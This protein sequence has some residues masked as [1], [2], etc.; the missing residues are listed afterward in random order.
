MP[1]TDNIPEEIWHHIKLASLPFHVRAVFAYLPQRLSLEAVLPAEREVIPLVARQLIKLALGSTH[2]D[3]AE[4]RL[5][6][7]ASQ[8]RVSLSRGTRACVLDTR[9]LSRDITEVVRRVFETLFTREEF[10][11]LLQRLAFQSATLATMQSITSHMLENTDVDRALYIM[12]SGLTSGYSLGFNRAALFVHDPVRGGFI[13]SR[14][15]GPASGLE[16]S[17]I[18]EEIEIQSKGIED[19]VEDYARGRFHTGFEEFIR[20]RSLEVSPDAADEVSA[21]LA[22]SGPLL[23]QRGQLVNGSLR[24]LGPAEEFLLAA[25]KPHGKLMGLIYADNVYNRAPIPPE[26]ITL[27]RFFIDQTALVWENL[28]LLRSV[29]ELARTDG[30]TGVL[31]RREFDRRVSEEQARCVRSRRPCSL[32]VIDIDRFK[33]T[34][35]TRGHEAGDEVLRTLGQ[36]LHQELRLSDLVGRLGGD[37]F[38]VFCSEQSRDQLRAAA[39]RLGCA[40]MKHGI[41]ISIGGATWPDDASDPTTLYRLADRF[42][43]RA[44]H[45]GRGQAC[46]GEQELLQFNASS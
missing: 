29:E 6:P 14:A 33:L 13:G 3:L 24:A 17:A 7:D 4:L 27:C 46:F 16:A 22:H 10:P 20:T 36:L 35:D 8:A 34:N 30:L 23:V 44:K 21:A 2:L 41:S 31:N 38:A 15:V 32:L 40:A 18:W 12:L 25:I 9:E 45:A 37:E 1:R 43:Y 19:L 26:R 5:V 42:L 28:E 11:D 39:V